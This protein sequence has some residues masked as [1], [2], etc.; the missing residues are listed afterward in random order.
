MTYFGFLLLFL[1]LPILLIV[2]AL[3][4]L[5]QGRAEQTGISVSRRALL[6]ATGVQVVLSVLYTT[7]WD[8]YL[9]AT[10][11]WNYGST[12]VTGI[13]V[14]YVPIEE[15]TFF[16]LEAILVGAW[17]S[18]VSRG[19]R[20]REAFEASMNPRVWAGAITGVLWLASLVM[21]LSGWK[22]GTYLSLIL[23]WALPPLLIQISY[24]GDILWHHRRLIGNV[25]IP[26]GL[27]LC[28]ADSVALGKGIWA[29]SPYQS[30]RILIGPLPVEEA[31]F[32]FVTVILLTFGVTLS[33]AEESR[34]RLPAMLSLLRRHRPPAT[35]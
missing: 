7:P 29:I 11:V 22:P 17:W 18:F 6:V 24:G 35:H 21:L 20:P 15:Y 5:P 23:A 30:T 16:V 10:G 27:Y 12:A 34:A 31:L 13:L 1:V 4:T 14:G 9:V 26:L 33:L 3:R 8:N 2:W 32:F 25:V 19:I 28:L